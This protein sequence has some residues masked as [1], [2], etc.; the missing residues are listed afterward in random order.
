MIELNF[1]SALQA[2]L[3]NYSETTMREFVYVPV[4]AMALLGSAAAFAEENSRA[5]PIQPIQPIQL[6]TGSAAD[7]GLADI[8]SA[9]SVTAEKP[10]LENRFAARSTAFSSTFNS[11]SSASVPAAEGIGTA[12]A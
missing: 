1:R 8:K 11:S 10:V 9:N 6:I 4:G 12:W 3:Q 7:N 5:G 2:A